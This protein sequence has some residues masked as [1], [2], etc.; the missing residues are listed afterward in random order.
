MLWVLSYSIFTTFIP[1]G[2]RGVAQQ[3]LSDKPDKNEKKL[4]K[5]VTKMLDHFPPQV[6]G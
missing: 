5:A 3:S 2:W 6:K 4:E 1:R